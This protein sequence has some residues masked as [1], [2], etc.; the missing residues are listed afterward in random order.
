MPEGCQNQTGITGANAK[1]FISRQCPVDQTAAS[2]A[3]LTWIP[4]AHIQSLPT[5]GESWNTTSF[6]EI[7]NA[8]EQYA[9]TFKTAS[10]SDLTVTELGEN[11]EG[12]QA[13]DIAFESMNT[14]PMKIEL[15][16]G[17]IYYFKMLVLGG[18]TALGTGTDV[19]TNTRTIQPQPGTFLTVYPENMFTVTF[20]AGA[21]GTLIGETSQRVV[22]GGATTAVYANPNTGYQ[23]TEWSDSTTT[24]PKTVTNVTADM[25][26]TASFVTV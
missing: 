20:V 11:D 1:V 5:V 2:Y 18:S 13:L 9:K 4:I 16:N 12:T 7:N 15:S 23:F 21:N 25:T 22:A 17:I 19:I 8:V 26:L 3:A 14:F 24:N 6:T 10:Q